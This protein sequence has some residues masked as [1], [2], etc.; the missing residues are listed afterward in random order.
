[1]IHFERIDLKTDGAESVITGDADVAHWPEQTYQVK[2]L[3]RFP[4]HA[5]AVLRA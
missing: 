2:S 4:S 5:R 1:M 3:G